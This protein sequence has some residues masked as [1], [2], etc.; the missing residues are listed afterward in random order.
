M[1]V[2]VA[3]AIPESLPPGQRHTGG[4]RALLH[5][6]GAVLKSRAFVGYLVMAFSMGVT[7]A[8]VATSAFILQSMNGLTPLQPCW[9][10]CSGRWLGSSLPLPASAVIR[11]QFLWL[12]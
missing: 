7:F 9:A 5:P 2:A 3:V 11:R 1:L 10:S 12:W 6:V 4:L 8:Y